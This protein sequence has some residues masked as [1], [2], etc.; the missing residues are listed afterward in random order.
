MQK[1]S[2]IVSFDIWPCLMSPATFKLIVQQYGILTVPFCGC[3]TQLS[4]CTY[5]L[6]EFLFG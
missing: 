4:S 3:M 6:V 2:H 5:Y 1:L